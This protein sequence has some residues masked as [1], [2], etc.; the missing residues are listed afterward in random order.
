MAKG[1]AD[2]Q[3]EGQVG[4][5]PEVELAMQQA[6]RQLD[7]FTEQL[8]GFAD[9]DTSALSADQGLKPENLSSLGPGRGLWQAPSFSLGAGQGQDVPPELMEMLTGGE[10]KGD[11]ESIFPEDRYFEEV[12]KEELKEILY[13]TG[14]FEKSFRGGKETAADF[15]HWGELWEGGA[16]RSSS[17]QSALSG[18]GPRTEEFR[19][20]DISSNPKAGAPEPGQAEKAAPM[21]DGPNTTADAAATPSMG[22]ETNAPRVNPSP[23]NEVPVPPLPPPRALQARIPPPPSPH[24]NLLPVSPLQRPSSWLSDSYPPAPRLPFTSGRPPLNGPTDTPPSQSPAAPQ[25]PT[26]PAAPVYPLTGSPLR[27]ASEQVPWP[28]VPPSPRSDVSSRPPLDQSKIPNG[29][30]KPTG[31]SSVPGSFPSGNVG[32]PRT[33]FSVEPFRSDRVFESEGPPTLFRTPA[34]NERSSP[35]WTSSS[36]TVSSLDG[37]PSFEEPPQS[38]GPASSDSPSVQFRETPQLQSEALRRLFAMSPEE[39][40]AL[41]RQLATGG[42]Q[43]QVTGGAA[44]DLNAPGVQSAPTATPSE[45]EPAPRQSSPSIADVTADVSGERPVSKAKT[46]D[47]I[48]DELST[49]TGDGKFGDFDAAAPGG[50]SVGDLLDRLKRLVDISEKAIGELAFG[51]GLPEGEEQRENSKCLPHPG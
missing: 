22:S 29:G 49:M 48:I 18:D 21:Q 42:A 51:G 2:G 24:P 32:F 45:K 9:F 26:P 16:G 50:G 3:S 37:P 14:G 11:E 34:L 8:Q 38:D 5:P 44:L 27:G 20:G 31:S 46:L 35:G 4:G 7:L 43:L 30:A 25:P 10:G 39:L 1:A 41:D 36:D 13:G 23:T 15:E 12:S 47:D 40:H 33:P 19:G 17:N 28:P 6:Q